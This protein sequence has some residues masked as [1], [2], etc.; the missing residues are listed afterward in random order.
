MQY[1]VFR[2]CERFG[3]IPPAA[4]QKWDDIHI[5]GQAAL[6]G[7]EQLREYEDAVENVERM[8]AMMPRF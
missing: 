7:Y 8:K 2:A 6:I 1:T 4:S 5:D 3:I